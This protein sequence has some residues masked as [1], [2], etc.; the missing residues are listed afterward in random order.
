M[1][2]SGTSTDIQANRFPTWAADDSTEI[3]VVRSDVAALSA[4]IAKREIYPESYGAL[5]GIGNATATRIAIQAA[6]TAANTVGGKV[7]FGVGDYYVDQKIDCTDLNVL[8]EGTNG[9][10]STGRGTKIYTTSLTDDVFY[11]A[12]VAES[13]SGV[14]FRDIQIMGNKA[15]GSAGSGIK[16]V[17]NTAGKVISGIIMNNV[18]INNCKDDGLYMTATSFIFDGS[19]YNLRT[20]GNGKRGVYG[21]NNVQQMTFYDNQNLSSGQENVVFEGDTVNGYQP[22]EIVFIRLVLDTA[23]STYYGARFTYCE[24]IGIDYIHTES[25]ATGQVLLESCANVAVKNGRI[26][27]TGTAKGIVISNLAGKTTKNISIDVPGW[28]NTS[29]QK[30]VEILLPSSSAFANFEFGFHADGIF[31]P[32]DVTGYATVFLSPAQSIYFVDN[33][34]YTAVY[35]PPSIANNASISTT[36]AVERAEVGN[37]VDATFS[38]TTAGVTV[39]PFVSSTGIVTCVFTNNTGASVDLPSGTLT[40]RLNLR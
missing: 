36:V 17:A 14:V 40:V 20:S 32:T 5:T 11:I 39:Y 12:A 18:Q 37:R 31:T 33:P 21:Q 13:I 35:D 10:G 15:L 22:Q 34:M 4:D 16:M 7:K 2:A 19:F 6:I 1:P 28:T 9:T 29:T 25:Q 30:R 8:V 23:G 3:A 38:I 26:S 24:K 27:Q